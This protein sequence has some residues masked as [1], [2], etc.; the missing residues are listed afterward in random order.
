MLSFIDISVLRFNLYLSLLLF[1]YQIKSLKSKVIIL[2]ILTT[3]S[4]SRLRF[5]VEKEMP[6]TDNYMKVPLSR[7]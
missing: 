6:E 1:Y 3:K 5:R 4:L 7:L 2:I